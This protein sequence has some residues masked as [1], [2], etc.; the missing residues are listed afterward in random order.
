M[1]LTQTDMI[2]HIEKHLLERIEDLEA[3]VQQLEIALRR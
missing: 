2:N 3:H 1:K